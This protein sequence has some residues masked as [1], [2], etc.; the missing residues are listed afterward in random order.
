MTAET[1]DELERA[2]SE[3]LGAW[4]DERAHQR[5]LVLAD[6]TGRLAEAGRRYRDVR[7]REPE[8]RAVAE[9]RIDEILGKAIAQMKVIESSEPAKARSRLEW[10][11]LGVS[12]ALIAAALW[13]LIR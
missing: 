6:A 5:F 11:G 10:I 9:R 12:A 13:Q 4:D 7:E 1:D 3:V 2:W 8:R